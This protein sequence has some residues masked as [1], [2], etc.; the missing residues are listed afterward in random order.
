MLLK[1]LSLVTLSV[2][3]VLIFIGGYVSA[4]GVGLSC[5]DWPLCPAGLLPSQEF[6]IEYIHRTVA[7]TTGVLVI[8]TMIVAIKDSNITK[9]VKLASIIAGSTVI[10]QIILGAI[11]IFEKLYSL[12]VT[13]HLGIGIILFSM[14]LIVTLYS[15]KF[16][17]R[18][19]PVSKLEN[20]TST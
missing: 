6:I 4:S 8:A 13:L 9:N 14:M 19:K 5:P 18:Q 2:L 16:S 12:L 11:V 3:F 15:W 1:I 20:S 17:W 7:A 10:I